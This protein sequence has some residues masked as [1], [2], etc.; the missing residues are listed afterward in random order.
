MKRSAKLWMP[1]SLLLALCLTAPAPPAA[2][3][4]GIPVYPGAAIDVDEDV[5]APTC[6]GFV[7]RDPASKV[8]AF[9][10]GVGGVQV[11]T[12]PEVAKRFPPM[13][14]QLRA[15]L[16][17]LPAGAEY[18]MLL[19][20]DGSDPAHVVE[21]LSVPG[22]TRFNL[23]EEQLGERG[24]AFVQEFRQKA[25]GKTSNPDPAAARLAAAYEQWFID[26]PLADGSRYPL[27][28][29]P[30][31]R[32]ATPD[33]KIRPGCWT[34]FHLTDAPLEKVAAFYRARL[35]P[36][37]R[38]EARVDEVIG[39][40]GVEWTHTTWIIVGSEAGASLEQGREGD[41][42]RSVVLVEEKHPPD[43]IPAPPAFDPE[44]RHMTARQI[45]TIKI[46]MGIETLGKGCVPIPQ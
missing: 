5:E 2:A 24:A 8:L 16:A 3:Q 23:N 46:S 44:L 27:P 29:F 45:P 14:A 38:E 30:G 22:M 42:N 26:H 9:Y 28:T 36:A 4:T 19:A 41:R 11:L 35:D 17:Q 37:F 7:T 34:T 21:V 43:M 25:G 39:V 13:A 40:R 10:R 1:V 33:E 6:C 18:H 12:P 15:M 32:L 31:A 20:G